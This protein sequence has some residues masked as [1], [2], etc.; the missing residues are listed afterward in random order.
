MEKSTVQNDE[1]EKTP[2]RTYDAS[3]GAM[4]VEKL[5]PPM[6]DEKRNVLKA[7]SRVLFL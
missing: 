5:F 4:L 6:L 1:T 3:E 7:K 2:K